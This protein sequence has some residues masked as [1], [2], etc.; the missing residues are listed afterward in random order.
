MKLK[1]TFLTVLIF[2]PLFS[3]SQEMMAANNSVGTKQDK[4]VSNKHSPYTA[5]SSIKPPSKEVTTEQN[6]INKEPPLALDIYLN[7]HNRW[8]L[9]HQNISRSDS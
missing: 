6:I 3:L 2:V 8:K 1:K 9:G 4:S 7:L 5:K